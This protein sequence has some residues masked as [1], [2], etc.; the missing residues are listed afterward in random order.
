MGYFM[1]WH[2]FTGGRGEGNLCHDTFYVVGRRGKRHLCAM[3]LFKVLERG[4][5]TL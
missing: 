3:A 4:W 1:S 2:F 5:C